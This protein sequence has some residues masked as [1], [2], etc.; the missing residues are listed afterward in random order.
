MMKKNT[1]NFRANKTVLFD[2]DEEFNG[3][4]LLPFRNWCKRAPNLAR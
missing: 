2:I 1:L 4:K 3:E